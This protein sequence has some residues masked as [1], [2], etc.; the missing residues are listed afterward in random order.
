MD[1]LAE[2][3]QEPQQGGQYPPS[4]GYPPGPVYAPGQMYGPGPQYGYPRPGDPYEAQYGG[5]SPPPS[6]GRY[7]FSTHQPGMASSGWPPQR[8]SHPGRLLVAA[9]V[10]AAVV[11]SG[12]GVGL[13]ATGLLG[14]LGWTSGTTAASSAPDNTIRQF[15]RTSPGS[16]AGGASMGSVGPASSSQSSG[17]VVVDTTLGYQ[18]ARAAGTGIVVQSN[19]L[20]VTNNHVVQGATAIT[21]TVVNS[22]RTYTASVVGTDAAHDIAVLKVNANGLTT[23]STSSTA[24]VTVG[25]SILAVGN[26][27]GTGVP[28]AATGTVTATNQSITAT[29]QN[30]QNPE[31]LTGLIE[32]SAPIQAGDSGGPLYDSQGKVIGIDT[33]AATNRR[34]ATTAGYAIPI[35]SAMTV[36]KQIITGNTSGGATIGLPAFLGVSIAATGGA[37]NGAAVAG[38]VP[39]GPAD[40]AGISAGDTI[41]AV[42][43]NTVASGSALRSALSGMHPG[44]QVTVTWVDANGQTQSATVTLVQ[45]PAA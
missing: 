44:Q 17:V 16:G 28:T 24:N 20:I 2:D 21:V 30:G 18:Q 45:G 43:G 15:P 1:P 33:A 13:V 39:G 38:V 6:G 26:A 34:G 35:G 29:D 40:L 14:R 37:G 31:N 10:T 36:A 23:V 22:G 12:V 27:G 8:R 32:T 4:P 42:G 5:W 19:G 9:L 11:V 3:P 7:N 41:V 25:E